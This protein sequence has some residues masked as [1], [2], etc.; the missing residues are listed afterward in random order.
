MKRLVEMVR[1]YLNLSRIENGELQPMMA[2]IP[3]LEDIIRP[4][5]IALEPDIEAHQ[6]HVDNQLPDRT[7][8]GDVNMLREVFENL[9]T[10]AIKYG[11]QGGT[12]VLHARQ[13]D[14]FVEF[15]V[16]NPGEG[17]PADKLSKVFQKFSRLN[18][19]TT[20]HQKGTGLGLFITKAIVEAHGGKIEIESHPNE[21]IELRFT[22]PVAEVNS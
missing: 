11:R 7:V 20:R 22:L 9:I 4:L 5:L 6:M 13:L 21:W 10:N 19:E 3:L 12:I 14:G 2:Q 1:H 17:I 8:H 18:T 16:R 15:A